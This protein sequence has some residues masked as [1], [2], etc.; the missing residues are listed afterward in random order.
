[1][2]KSRATESAG[3]ALPELLVGLAIL[4]IVAAAAVP[5]WTGWRDR[6][7]LRRALWHLQAEVAALSAAAAR[8]GRTRA[9]VF[10]FA[11]GGLCWRRV[12]DGDG[13]GVSRADVGTGRDPVEGKRR[14]LADLGPGLRAGV[15]PAGPSRG[16][17]GSSIAADGVSLP[18][19]LLSVTATGSG[20]SGTVYLSGRGNEVV[21][22]RRYGVTGRS[23]LWR[24]ESDGDRWS[25]L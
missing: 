17:G 8:D 14:C 11:A 9:L 13:D 7:R 21:A 6:Q 12:R 23:T 16:P 10:G 20:S 2:R 25:R 24:C 22:L 3:L 5:G 18:G 19:D 4:G 15:G 1:M